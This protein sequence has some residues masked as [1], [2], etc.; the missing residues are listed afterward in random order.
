[1]EENKI[2][3]EKFRRRA[4]YEAVFAGL[5]IAAAV[6]VVLNVNIGSV[7]IPV[8]DIARILTVQNESAAD[9]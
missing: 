2:L 5:V 9:A 8:K 4:R 6:I 7:P 1:M 3:T